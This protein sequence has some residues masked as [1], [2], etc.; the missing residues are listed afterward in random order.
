MTKKAIRIT[1]PVPKLRNP[2]ASIARKHHAGAHTDRRRQSRLAGDWLTEWLFDDNGEIAGCTP[3]PEGYVWRMRQDLLV[4]VNAIREQ[5]GL[6]SL[7]AHSLLDEAAQTYA[8]T[9]A[10][11]DSWL[12]HTG[13]D[14]STPEDRIAATGYLER[15]HTIQGTVEYRYRI[16]ENLARGQQSTDEALWGWMRSPGHRE[17]ILNPEFEETG[18]GIIRDCWVQVF[19]TVTT[20]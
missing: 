9:I 17:N 16:G 5:K 14:G 13:P 11:I 2:F 6:C 15:I 18:I 3:G 10:D 12:S 20:G 1:V 4:R 19:G 8:E 7:R